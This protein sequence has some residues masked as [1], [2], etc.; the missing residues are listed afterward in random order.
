[1]KAFKERLLQPYRAVS[2]YPKYSVST[3][4]TPCYGRQLPPDLGPYEY[5]TID[6]EAS[7]IRLITILPDVF[8]SEVRITI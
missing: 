8:G 4:I 3:I 5:T 7:E 2:R 6:K 1:M